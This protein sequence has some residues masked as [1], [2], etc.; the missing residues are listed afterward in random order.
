[1]LLLVTQTIGNQYLPN[2]NAD[3]IDNG[4]E[5][6]DIRYIWATGG[7]MLTIA[8]AVGGVAIVAVYFASRIAMGA[9]ADIRAAVFG[10]VQGFSA[11][12]MNRFGTRR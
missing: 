3:I 1:M 11:R 7:V 5:K 8:L 9:G 12:A 6:G 2:L 10:R 4:V